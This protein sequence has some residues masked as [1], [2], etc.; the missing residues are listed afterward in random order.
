MSS[1]ME[2]CDDDVP[3]DNIYIVTM[4]YTTYVKLYSMGITVELIRQEEHDCVWA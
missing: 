2:P 1:L 3:T 4:L